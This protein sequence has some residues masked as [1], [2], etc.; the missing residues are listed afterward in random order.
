ME[1]SL[2]AI[3][4]AVSAAAEASPSLPSFRAALPS[5]RAALSA[6][7]EVITLRRVVQVLRDC[8]FSDDVV[9]TL[10]RRL[11]G[12][13]AVSIR[14]V[15][16]AR[17]DARPQCCGFMTVGFCCLYDICHHP[18]TSTAR[19]PNFSSYGSGVVHALKG[20]AC[21]ASPSR[22]CLGSQKT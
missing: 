6:Y 14:F 19:V 18:N 10:L 17:G 8:G 16:I 9:A 11:L 13:I 7:G 2:S 5:I 21:R 4:D 1:L 22:A 15:I 20:L 12:A 3:L